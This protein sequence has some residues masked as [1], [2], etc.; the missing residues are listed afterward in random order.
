MDETVNLMKYTQERCSR[1]YWDPLSYYLI[2]TIG[3]QQV[4]NNNNN[5]QQQSGL[6]LQEG[7]DTTN[8]TLIQYLK[9]TIVVLGSRRAMRISCSI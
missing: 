2:G 8:S 1:V 7:E 3:F 9:D 4:Y 5:N 6:D